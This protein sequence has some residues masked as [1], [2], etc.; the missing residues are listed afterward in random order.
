MMIM[1]IYDVAM[2]EMLAEHVAR[3][4]VESHAPMWSPEGLQGRGSPVRASEMPGWRWE[5]VRAKLSSSIPGR[6][7]L[8]MPV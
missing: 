6:A 5:L 8:V 7:R 1:M 2:R 3:F 4:L